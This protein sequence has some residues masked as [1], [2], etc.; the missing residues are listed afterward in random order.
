M[1]NKPRK[2]SSTSSISGKMKTKTPVRYH[3]PLTGMAIMTF[4]KKQKIASVGKDVEQLELFYIASG[5]EK[6]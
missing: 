2:R 5:N 6:W 3:F 1:A 4:S